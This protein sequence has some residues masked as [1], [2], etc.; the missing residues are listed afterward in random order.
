[1]RVICQSSIGFQTD[2]IPIVHTNG[3]LSKSESEIYF[4]DAEYDFDNLDVTIAITQAEGQTP[5]K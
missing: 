4:E 3:K 2:C 5:Q 1:M